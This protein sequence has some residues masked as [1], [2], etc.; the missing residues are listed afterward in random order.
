MCKKGADE[1]RKELDW[2]PA[3][4]QVG[5]NISNL[6]TLEDK[7]LLL[8]SNANPSPPPH[9]HQGTFSFL[10]LF[11]KSQDSPIHAF[12][13]T[14]KLPKSGGGRLI[15]HPSLGASCPAGGLPPEGWEQPRLLV[16]KVHTHEV[17]LAKD[18]F[19]RAS[20]RGKF[21]GWEEGIRNKDPYRNVCQLLRRE[22]HQIE[23]WGPNSQL[24]P[25]LGRPGAPSAFRGSL[26]HAQA[27]EP[28][29]TAS[30]RPPFIQSVASRQWPICLPL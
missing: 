23:N 14:E 1:G 11:F 4:L 21:P 7:T 22:L 27:A 10:C 17:S 18:P 9:T 13:R 8:T 15:L 12:S 28:A 24:F 30:G 2:L 3:H 29:R 5:L 25:A 6:C 20:S 19:F 26:G 16:W